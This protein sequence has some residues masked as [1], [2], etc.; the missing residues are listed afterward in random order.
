MAERI[1]PQFVNEKKE[2]WEGRRAE[3][4]FIAIMVVLY[5]VLRLP[6]LT[7]LPLMKDEVLYSLM[8]EEQI[9]HP[10][11]A[12]TLFGYDMPWKPP[13]FFWVYGAMIGLLKEVG[14]AGGMPI[15]AIYRYPSLLFGAI[16]LLLVYFLMK[17]MIGNTA[18]LFLS[19][20]VY[21]VILLNIYLSNTALI[22]TLT[23]TF[24]YGAILCYLHS[25]RSKWLYLA[26]WILVVLAFITKLFLALVAPAVAV[27]Y[28]LFA[29][30]KRLLDW[31]FLASLT[32]PIVG[33]LLFYLIFSDASIQSGVYGSDIFGKIGETL[34]YAQRL[35]QSFYT[36]FM[37]TNV[38]FAMGIF[39]AVKYWK[40]NRAM[41]IW[42]LFIIFPLLAAPLMP[43][44]FAMILPPL[45][46]FSACVFAYD[47]TRVKIDTFTIMIILAMFMV[48]LVFITSFYWGYA[49]TY[50]YE[51]QAGDLLVF[52]SNVLV[53]G[54][55]APTIIAEKAL[56]EQKLNGKYDD[57]GWIFLIKN[58][59][60]TENNSAV[61]ER[62]IKDYWADPKT[63][64]KIYNGDF[65]R[66]FWGEGIFRKN[67]GIEKFDYVVVTGTEYANVL[68]NGTQIYNRANIAIYALDSVPNR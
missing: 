4:L 33:A 11:I 19:T 58:D 48:S 22:D 55:Y 6:F 26:A 16:N 68:V 1:S 43:W 44:H 52:K 51:K 28:F 9:S 53:I 2:I 7:T 3:I 24:V 62:L 63:G 66:M 37:T 23:L 36:L 49:E 21:N 57:F 61:V 31:K 8:V 64:L 45:A 67:T 65:S 27:A 34:T 47:K 30:K 17:K 15:E 50:S 59:N 10:T 5:F 32:A 39:G 42:L 54:E 12:P 13:V 46:Y 18:I 60:E 25:N 56:T 35:G 29:D 20:F 14:L 41:A 40:T 38:W